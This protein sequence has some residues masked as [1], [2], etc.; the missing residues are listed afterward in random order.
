MGVIFSLK[1]LVKL[2]F[3]N[4]YLCKYRTIER[5]Y[6]PMRGISICHKPSYR[7]ISPMRGVLCGDSLHIT[8]KAVKCLSWLFSLLMSIQNMLFGIFDWLCLGRYDTG[9]LDGMIR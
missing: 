3:Y 7:E 5:N 4:P 6:R 1:Y 9:I 8:P 2:Y